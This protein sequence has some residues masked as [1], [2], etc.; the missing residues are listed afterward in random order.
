MICRKL[1]LCMTEHD[2]GELYTY[3]ELFSKV[4][5]GYETETAAVMAGI[6]EIY[7]EEYRPR[8]A[9]TAL[10]ELRNPRCAGRKS[11]LT[12]EQVSEIVR[13][14]S[15]RMSI[16]EISAVTGLSRS[17]VQRVLKSERSKSSHI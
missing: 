7:T 17:S 8:D 1:G 13:L 11:K 10:R 16:R 6:L 3:L 5:G 14:R 4:Y 9:D 15:T 2:L 12:D